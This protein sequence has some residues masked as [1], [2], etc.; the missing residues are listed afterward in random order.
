[1]T[2]LPPLTQD[3]QVPQLQK[4]NKVE[5]KQ[6][7]STKATVDKVADMS[8]KKVL[9][10][11]TGLVSYKDDNNKSVE[12]VGIKL[13]DLK[14]KDNLKK[15][16]IDCGGGMLVIKN[17]QPT[18]LHMECDLY[19]NYHKVTNKIAW[20]NGKELTLESN[21]ISFNSLDPEKYETLIR[22]ALKS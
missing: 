18:S 20:K 2:S 22:A 13:I 14:N 11:I 4:L 19:K 15:I 3:I 12:C 1:M 21:L 16:L 8:V 6:I 17:G 7:Q 10:E 5:G 9:V